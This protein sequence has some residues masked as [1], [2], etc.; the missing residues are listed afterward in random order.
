MII[1]TPSRL[2]M[3]LIDLNGSYGRFDGG[4]GLTLNNPHFVLESE[5]TEK[6]ITIDFDDD[7]TNPEVLDECITKYLTLQ[8]K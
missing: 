7:I 2:H 4:I 8:K 5:E 6:G 1:K 3:T